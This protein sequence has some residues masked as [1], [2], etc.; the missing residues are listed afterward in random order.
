[1]SAKVFR[2]RPDGS[3]SK[4]YYNGKDEN[5][6]HG[7]GRF[8]VYTGLVAFRLLS[9]PRSFVLFTVT[10]YRFYFVSTFVSIVLAPF[11]YFSS[12]LSISHSMWSMD[13]LAR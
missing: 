5:L 7:H 6:T 12:V 11:T 4:K 10:I 8:Y 1:M 9:V 13:S 2:Y 3:G